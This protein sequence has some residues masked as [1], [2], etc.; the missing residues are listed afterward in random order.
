MPLPAAIAIL[1]LPGV[2]KTRL[3]CGLAAALL[4]RGE[5]ALV[6]HTDVLKVTARALDQQ[7]AEALRGPGFSGDLAAKAACMHPILA[8]HVVKA[9][10]DSYSVVIEGTLALGFRAEDTVY[11]LLEVDE[12][13]RRRR[14]GHKHASAVRTLA[15]SDLA[16]Y[17]AALMQSLPPSTLRLDAAAPPGALVTRTLEWIRESWH[18]AA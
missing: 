16:P 2:G 7:A 9:R 14:V 18:Y 8:A 6:V 4:D 15:D 3:A 11:V 5:A 17:A 10:R 12:T 13:E 1:G